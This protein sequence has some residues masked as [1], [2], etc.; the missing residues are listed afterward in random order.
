MHASSPDWGSPR[1][2]KVSND[3]LLYG[4]RKVGLG[5]VSVVE[6]LPCTCKTLGS[7]PT[8]RGEKLGTNRRQVG[9][10]GKNTQTN[11]NKL[12]LP[13]VKDVERYHLLES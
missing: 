7:I 2:Q 6:C 12:F 1:E 4:I 8:T 3:G 5:Y 13:V 10:L 11:Q 9:K